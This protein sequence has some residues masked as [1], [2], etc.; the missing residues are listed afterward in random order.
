MTFKRL[1]LT[2]DV[3]ILQYHIQRENP[4]NF[5]Q[6][7]WKEIIISLTLGSHVY[8]MVKEDKRAILLKIW[9]KLNGLKILYSALV[10]TKHKD[11]KKVR[12]RHIRSQEMDQ[13]YILS[14][15]KKN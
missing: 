15:K 9:G 10:S 12:F 1:K 4:N 13:L 3:E 8:C 6:T 5:K 11:K 2:D 7:A 14:E